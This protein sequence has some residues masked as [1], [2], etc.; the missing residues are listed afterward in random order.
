MVNEANTLLPKHTSNRL[1]NAYWNYNINRVFKFKEIGHNLWIEKVS[2]TGFF[3]RVNID[4]LSGMAC[5]KLISTIGTHECHDIVRLLH[6]NYMKRG[7]IHLTWKGVGISDF[8]IFKMLV[9]FVTIDAI[10]PILPYLNECQ[11]KYS[12]L[13][14]FYYC[15]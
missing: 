7:V 8:L 14:Q 4:S 3:L 1:E 13:F 9:N 15:P 2:C 6:L 5:L 10:R 11:C 12:S